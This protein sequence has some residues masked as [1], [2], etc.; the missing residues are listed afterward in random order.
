MKHLMMINQNESS[1]KSNMDKYKTIKQKKRVFITRYF[2]LNGIHEKDMSENH[3]V[4]VNN[5]L[6]GASETIQENIDQ[7]V[8]SKPD[9]LIVHA[10]TNYLAIKTNLL[11]QG[12]NS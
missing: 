8:K 9:C 4:K 10:G 1:D 3:K 2:I 6:G 12:K 7:L 5:F 11:N